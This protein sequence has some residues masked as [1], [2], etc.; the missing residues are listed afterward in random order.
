MFNSIIAIPYILPNLFVVW[1][2]ENEKQKSLSLKALTNSGFMLYRICGNHAYSLWGN[3][4]QCKSILSERPT[5]LMNNGYQQMSRC[6][7]AL[8]FQMLQ[9]IYL[10]LLLV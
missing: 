2:S 1:I 8:T 10:Q 3:I 6:R 4:S 7:V 5:P 9:L